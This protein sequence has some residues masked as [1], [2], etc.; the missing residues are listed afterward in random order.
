MRAVDVPGLT[1]SVFTST[2]TGL[3]SDAMRGGWRSPGFAVRIIAA[4]A[5]LVGAV[6]GAVL[7]LKTYAWCAPAFATASLVPTVAWSHAAARSSAPW[8]T[9]RT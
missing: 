4:L 3:A 9:P 1:T 8:A 7:A 5:L 6:V 2:L